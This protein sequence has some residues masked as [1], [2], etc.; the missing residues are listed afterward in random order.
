MSLYSAVIMA[1]RSFTEGTWRTDPWFRTLC[2]TLA[3]CKSESAVADF[4]RDVATLSELQA[5]SERLEVARRIAAGQTY[6]QIAEQT[7]ASTTTVTR[8]GNF[9]MGGAG[10]YRK[11][12]KFS[13]VQHQHHAASK[14]EEMLASTG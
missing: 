3:E 1:K 7:G 4:L 12:L 5:M 8:V 9:L 11:T 13:V 6:R 2:K 14:R 10:G